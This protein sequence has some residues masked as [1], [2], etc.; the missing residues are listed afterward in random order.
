[1]TVKDIFIQKG[2]QKMLIDRFLEQELK[3][4]GYAGVD[5]IRTPLGTRIT[6]YAERPGMVIGR[7]GSNI[8]LLTEK[9]QKLFNIENPQID[10]IP[11]EK[12]ELNAKIMAER[13]ARALERGVR[14]RR[15][16]FIALRQIMEAGARGAEIII[17]GKLRSERARTEKYS[18]G[19]VYKS[20]YPSEAM[21]DEAVSYALLK[22]GIYGIKVRITLPD[23]PHPDDIKIKEEVSEKQEKEEGEEGK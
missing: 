6:I 8:R 5:I 20:G 21:V 19:V 23:V 11:V 22:P 12:P 17:S 15:A 1:M 7:R 13:I 9:L 14:F 16:A 10:V 4:A 2:I 18:A 3:R